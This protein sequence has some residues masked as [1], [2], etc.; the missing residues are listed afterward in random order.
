MKQLQYALKNTETHKAGT[1]RLSNIIPITLIVLLLIAVFSVPLVSQPG[2]LHAETM[3]WSIVNTPDNTNNVVVSPSEINALAAGPDG[4]TFFAADIPHS[5]LYRSIDGGAGWQDISNNLTSAGATLPVW[6]IITASD[7]PNF[8]AAVTTAAG[9]PGQVFISTDG[10]DSW[11]N[12]GCPAT[13][14]ISAIDISP[15]YGKYDVIVGTR[16]GAG[17]GKVYIFQGF[18]GWADQ[19]FTGDVLA[20]KCSPDYGNDSSYAITY[21]DATGTYV[22]LGIRDIHANFTNWSLWGPVEITTSGAGSSPKANQ[23]IT[24]DLELPFDFSGQIAERRRFYVATNDA[25]VSGNAGIYRIDDTLVYRI[26]TVTGTKMISSIAY[27]GSYHSGK[28][29][30]GEVKADPSKATVDIWFSPNPWEICPQSACIQWQKAIKPPTGGANSGNAN[31]QVLWSPDGSRA[32]CGTSSANLDV[33]GWPNGYMTAA[34][35]D[36]SAF[37]LSIDNGAVWNQLSLIDTVLSFLSDVVAS[38]GSDVLYLAS[39]NSN[40][41]YTGF[42]SLW[43]STSFPHG[44]TWERVYCLLS[45]ADDIIVRI[46]SSPAPQSVVLACRSSSDLFHSLDTGQSWNKVL[47]GVTITDCAHSETD[48]VLNIYIL[49]GNKVRRGDYKNGIWKWG[50]TVNTNLST[51]HSITAE[52]GGLVVTGD[53]S[54]GM[55]AYSIDGG[56]QFAKLP[57][58]PESGNVHVI[59]DTRIFNYIILYAASDNPASQVYSWVINESSAWMPMG[60]PDRQFYGLAQDNTLYCAWSDGANSG[61]NR[62]LMPESLGPPAIEWGNMTSGLSAGVVFTRE[63]VSLKASGGPILWAID[64]RAYSATTGRLWTYMDCLSPTSQPVVSPSEVAYLYQAPT[65]VSPEDGALIPEDDETEKPSD[66]KFKWQHPTLAIGYELVIAEDESFDNIVLHKSITPEI[67]PSPEWTLTSKN[68]P[69]ETGKTYYWIIRVYRDAN[70]GRGA[71]EWST[72]MS[73]RTEGQQPEVP[74]APVEELEL[75]YPIDNAFDIG[76]SPSF[77]WSSMEN[78]AGYEFILAT[79]E[80][81]NNIIIRASVPEATYVHGGQLEPGETYYWQVTTA[82]STSP[83]FHFTV[84]DDMAAVDSSQGIS[85]QMIFWI[86]GIVVLCIIIVVLIIVFRH[87]KTKQAG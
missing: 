43:R 1:S 80:Q 54:Q 39:V 2:A 49:D 85:L 34:A 30:A 66:I 44:Q 59:A 35:R 7:N 78:A 45:P 63:P 25:N 46:N 17:N 26:M 82:D 57:A 87:K 36:E 24:A 60:T 61:T 11:Q 68:S 42:D 33:A 48:D 64:N 47:P 81:L 10:G 9:I 75:L 32:Y 37:S 20:I 23:V 27:Y 21:A 18:G 55:V 74:Q 76:R 12:T 79:D 56:T 14:A 86:T 22:A 31:A 41:G 58:L 50:Q 5:K 83:V 53:A 38:P 77:R 19:G 51:G 62:A 65:P 67:P 70:Y 73:F 13:N 71:G 6:N 4:I 8:V 15:N 72:I 16:T 29:L 40:A 69:L 84:T 3:A 28:L 52:P